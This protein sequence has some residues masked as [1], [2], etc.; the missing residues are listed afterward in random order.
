[1]LE[2]NFEARRNSDDSLMA[3]I[4][5][6]GINTLLIQDRELKE[7]SAHVEGFNDKQG[8]MVS[9]TTLEKLTTIIEGIHMFLKLMDGGSNERAMLGRLC[10]LH[11]VASRLT[12]QFDEI[13]TIELLDSGIKKAIHEIE[14][15]KIVELAKNEAMLNTITKSVLFHAVLD[16]APED[17]K[18]H[19]KER[20]MDD[21]SEGELEAILK[22]YDV[23][24][25]EDKVV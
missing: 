23:D 3:R 4:M 25:R 11:D 2:I 10:F 14:N 9:F 12:Q 5:L 13:T 24:L 1:M 17:V 21:V 6:D 20:G 16:C 8:K 22:L 15:S 19:I 18:A 7:Y